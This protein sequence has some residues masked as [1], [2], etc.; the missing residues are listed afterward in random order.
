M[1]I[2]DARRL[3]VSRIKKAQVEHE[4]AARKSIT[5]EINLKK[6][7]FTVCLIDDVEKIQF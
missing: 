6:K 2:D 4:I 5:N 3:R 1:A 7:R